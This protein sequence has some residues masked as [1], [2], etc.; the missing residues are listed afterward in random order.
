MVTTSGCDI[1]NKSSLSLL[2]LRPSPIAKS[3]MLAAPG[4]KN[5]SADPAVLQGLLPEPR[6]AQSRFALRLL[7]PGYVHVYI[8][9]PPA[10]VKNW[11]IYRVNERADLIPEGHALFSQPDAS[12]PCKRPEHIATGMKV[13]NIPQAH[14]VSEIWIAFSANLWNE[15]LRGSNKADPAV[16]QKISLQSCGLNSF[17]PTAENLKAKVLECALT[18]L[19]IDKATDHDFPFTSLAGQVNDLAANL[20]R[21]AAK[22][23]KT[24]GKELAVVLNDPVGI[25]TELNALRIRR[26]EI[27]KREI[28]KPENLHPLSSSHTILGLRKC[29]VDEQDLHSY[30][31]VSPI[32]SLKDF[33]AAQWPEGTQWQPL[34]EADRAKLLERSKSDSTIGQLL[35]SPYKKVFERPDLGRVIYPDHDERAAAWTEKKVKENWSKYE[36]Y[37]DEGARAAWVRKFEAKMK[38]EH[39]VPLEALEKD[40]NAARKGQ[41]I[42]TYF[43]RHFDRV[44][45][46]KSLQYPVDFLVDAKEH[47]YISLPMPFVDGPVMDDYVS[48][49]DLPVTDENAHTIRSMV[50]GKDLVVKIVHKQLT[51][52]PGLEDGGMRD[53]T[54][55]LVK[56]FS[57]LTMSQPAMQSHG[58]IGHALAL[59]SINQY[60]ALSGA[61]LT[62]AARQATVTG[63]T[64]RMLEKLQNLALVQSALECAVQ[65]AIKGQ[66]PKIPVMI[67]MKVSAENALKILKARPGQVLGTSKRRIKQ[68][69]KTNRTIPLVLITDTEA[70]K[71]AN[72]KLD[73]LARGSQGSSVKMGKAVDSTVDAR[74]LSTVAMS[75]ETFLRLYQA[76]AGRAANAANRL[77]SV[78]PDIAQSSHGAHAISVAKTLD[79][80]LALAS[81]VI[82]T[83]G[84]VNGLATASKADS[85]SAVEDAEYGVMDSVFG[86]MGGAFALWVVAAEIDIAKR[87]GT[88][89]VG[90]SAKIGL[91]RVA[92]NLTGIAGGVINGIASTKKYRQQKGD[93][94]KV[95]ADLYLLSVLAFYGTAVTSF[96]L[97]AGAIASALEARVIGGAVVRTVATRIGVGTVFASAVSGVGLLLLGIGVVAQITAI[98]LTPSDFERWLARS[99]FGKGGGGLFSMQD[100]ADKFKKGDWGSEKAALEEMIAQAEKKQ[101]KN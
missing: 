73:I 68:F 30:E 5:I 67:T 87:L 75:E 15:T 51:G 46:P 35:L 39:Y 22:H 89:A 38:A 59:F 3:P 23:P 85:A 28:A 58:W 61:V 56:G 41:Q 44:C 80:R 52:S 64:A 90:T 69:A 100:R 101:N 79:A 57:E 76:Q 49:L 83:I 13:L 72:G 6:P 93:G 21:A 45:T 7:R 40:W 63:A 43:T 9:Q 62:I 29:L 54:F 77:R 53:K 60:A 70:I 48:E 26:N 97:T 71:A 95:P 98:V 94:N 81:M 1:C 18:Q 31:Q 86:F 55:D 20:A 19:S 91:L 12:V 47:E 88:Q 74:P 84:V 78:I 32:R 37:Y 34:T 50:G 24:A 99:Y 2:L 33:E 4:S 10:G 14:K 66:A 8:P 96:T 92:G 17:V 42:S 27:V 65:G 36:D 16:M 25:A 82:Q 11:L